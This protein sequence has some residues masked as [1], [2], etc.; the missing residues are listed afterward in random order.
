MHFDKILFEEI[1][2]IVIIFVHFGALH[3]LVTLNV[4]ILFKTFSFFWTIHY[5]LFNYLK[6]AFVKSFTSKVYFATF[7]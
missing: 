4:A 7:I 3:P 6:Q 1:I 5:L 2:L